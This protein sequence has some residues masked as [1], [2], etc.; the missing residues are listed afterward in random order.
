MGTGRLLMGAKRT[1]LRTSLGVLG[2]E[3]SCRDA[4]SEAMLLHPGTE[5]LIEP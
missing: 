1:S 5:P 4:R 2:G 3:A